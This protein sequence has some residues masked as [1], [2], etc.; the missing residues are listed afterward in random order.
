MAP[1]LAVPTQL[2][3]KRRAEQLRS[4]QPAA[5]ADEAEQVCLPH[6]DPASGMLTGCPVVARL[7]AVSR[8]RPAGNRSRSPCSSLT[9]T[10]RSRCC[11]APVVLTPVASAHATRWRGTLPARFRFR[12]RRAGW[13]VPAGR[14]AVSRLAAT[15]RTC[16]RRH[17]ARRGRGQPLESLRELAA[18]ATCL[19]SQPGMAHR[20]TAMNTP[21]T[22]AS[23]ATTSTRVD[24]AR[25][26]GTGRRSGPGHRD[27][28]R[29]SRS[30]RQ[31]GA[32]SPSPNG[33]HYPA[34]RCAPAEA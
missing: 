9:S 12:R 1:T 2:V 19:G 28:R 13:P 11:P 5:P 24:T 20:G 22:A 26:D 29:A 8:R 33:E 3:W 10:T 16:R 7:A 27:S 34:R 18:D 30:C 6:A 32:S 25:S 21:T 15:A 31:T 4:A 23:S 17:G 14:R